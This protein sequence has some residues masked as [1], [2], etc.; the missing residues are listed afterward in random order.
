[1]SGKQKVVPFPTLHQI[2]KTRREISIFPPSKSSRRAENSRGRDYETPLGL[3]TQ[4]IFFAETCLQNGRPTS[5]L[6]A[7]FSRNSPSL[8]ASIASDN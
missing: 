7:R 2:N 4:I 5:I 6:T 1:M 8:A 3:D